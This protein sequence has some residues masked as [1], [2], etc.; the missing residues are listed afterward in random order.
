MWWKQSAKGIKGDARSAKLF[1]EEAARVGLGEEQ[2]GG[3]SPFL[4]RS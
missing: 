3:F 1:M 2:E 4:S